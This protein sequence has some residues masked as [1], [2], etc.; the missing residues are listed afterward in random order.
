MT[1][2]RLTLIPG[3]ADLPDLDQAGQR[4]VLDDFSRRVG[5]LAQA[6]AT[7][8]GWWFSWLSSRDRH[9]CPLAEDLAWLARAEAWLA[10]RDGDA[11]LACPAPALA[12]ALS[13]RARRAGWQVRSS[14]GLWAAALRA[15]AAAVIAAV[16]DIAKAAAIGLINWRAARR[17]PCRHLGGH[18]V[19]LVAW[20]DHRLINARTPYESV[21]FGPLGTLLEESGETCLHFGPVMTEPGRIDAVTRAAMRDDAHLAT[22]GH[23]LTLGDIAASVIG[24]AAEKIR[25]TVDDAPLARRALFRHIIYSAQARMIERATTRLLA[26]NPQARVIRIYENLP[27]ERAVDL[28]ARAAGR[29]VTGYLH[30]AVLPCYLNY[31]IDE[32][33]ARV[34]PRPDRIACTGPAARE[35]LLSLGSHD[36]AE[37]RAGMAL[38]GP[39][40][41]ALKLRDERSRPIRRV[42][43]LLEGLPRMVHLLRTL[44]DAAA[45]LPDL[46]F[47]VRAH[48]MMPLDVLIKSGGITAEAAARLHKAAD[49]SLEDNIRQADA[50]IYQ[51]TTAALTAALM[52]LPLL[53]FDGH[54]PV[55][56]DPL[57][58]CDAFKHTFD[59]PD[60]LA[61]AIGRLDGLDDAQW[62]AQRDTLRA[63][64]ADYLRA[65]SAAGLSDFRIAPSGAN[66]AD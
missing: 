12:A 2:K 52:G 62:R 9:H 49:G 35:V 43:V 58:R 8:R 27:W 59:T 44:A 64:V 42:L 66:G 56:D 61:Q 38:R 3:P 41:A 40:P 53:R 57:C 50:I 45:V 36:P 60:T 33:D 48:P 29:D 31:Y 32:D 20:L 23:L 28:A 14:P 46:R 15:R 11:T 30:C 16:T 10:Q 22:L 24:A 1:L 19:I 18:D 6:N 34:R 39:N 63:Y 25:W 65:P 54:P 17:H 21:Y 7:R 37:I 26:L 5:R 55:T 51:G 13:A 47:E 4:A